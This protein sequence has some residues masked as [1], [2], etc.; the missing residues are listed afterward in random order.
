MKTSPSTL[1][2]DCCR[3]ACHGRVQAL[4][5]LDQLLLQRLGDK[6]GDLLDDTELV[7]VLAG[8]W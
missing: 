1:P 8:V 5:Q 7:G 4:H 2:N 3:R 6:T